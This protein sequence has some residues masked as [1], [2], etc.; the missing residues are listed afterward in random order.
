MPK[1]RQVKPNIN[2]AEI[3]KVLCPRCTE[4]VKQLVGQ[5]LAEQAMRE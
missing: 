5:K 4:K 2:L 3:A 1:K